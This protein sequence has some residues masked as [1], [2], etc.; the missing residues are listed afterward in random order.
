[1]KKITILGS[2][3]SIGNSTL[4]VIKANPGEYRVVAL[5]AG[6]NIDLLYE[7]IMTFQ[8]VAAAVSRGDLADALRNRLK[9]H[10][11]TEIL[12]GSKGFSM[13]AAIDEADTVI[14]AISGASGLIPTYEAIRAGKGIALANKETMVMA[15]QIIMDLAKQK[16]IPILPIDSEHSAIFQSLQGHR[17]E[18]LKRVILT[19]SGGPFRRLSLDEMKDV[20]PAMALKH[21]NWDMGRKISIDSATLMNKGLEVIE[22]RW[23]FDLRM[24]QIDILVHPESIIHSMVEYMDGSVIAQLGIPDMITPISYALSWPRH[25]KTDLPPLKLE[26]VGRLTFERPDMGRFRCLALAL[27]AVEAGESMPAVMNGANE[28][29]VGLFLDNRIKFLQIPEIIER[30]M[31]AHRPFN[32]DGIEA[33]MEADAWARGVAEKEAIRLGA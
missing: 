1:M 2:T 32:P 10:S 20:T 29:A 18:D 5:A 3:G 8:P 4:K 21:P 16:N 30:T 25:I 17:K 23:L 6:N 28:T 24:D 33:I 9:G 19:A 13:L 14:S 27:K 26:E 31:D 7:Q 15:G 22:A 12:S 11:K